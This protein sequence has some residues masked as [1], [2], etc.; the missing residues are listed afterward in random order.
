MLH[1][2]PRR[3]R[4][5][6]LRDSLF[7]H[8]HR[9]TSTTPWIAT[10]PHPPRSRPRRR[11]TFGDPAS[12]RFPAPRKAPPLGPRPDGHHHLRHV[13]PAL[14]PGSDPPRRR[15]GARDEPRGRRRAGQGRADHPRPQQLHGRLQGP[16]RPQAGPGSPEGREP[17]HR[18]RRLVQQD[19]GRGERR[20]TRST[21]PTAAATTGPQCPQGSPWKSQIAAIEIQRRGRHQRLGRRDLEPAREPRTSTT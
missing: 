11:S 14:V 10:N 20:S 6:H 9:G 3:N 4:A 13:G 2:R 5:L 18:H 15:A 17:A 1:T 21:S 7:D 16:P 19:P 8:A 12:L